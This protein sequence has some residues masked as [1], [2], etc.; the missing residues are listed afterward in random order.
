MLAAE[1]EELRV[2]HALDTSFEQPKAVVYLDFQ[3]PAAL[4]CHSCLP[5]FECGGALC[6]LVQLAIS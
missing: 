3:V 4:P 1:S 5:D 6:P 2:F